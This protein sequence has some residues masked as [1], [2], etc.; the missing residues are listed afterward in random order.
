MSEQTAVE[1]TQVERLQE[2]LKHF[3]SERDYF[4]K[5]MQLAYDSN[6]SL[7]KQYERIRGMYE[8]RNREYLD[9]KSKMIQWLKSENPKQKSIATCEFI[10]SLVNKIESG[11]FDSKEEQ[12][13]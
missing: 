1:G 6:K 13:K 2:S 4:E 5:E 3:V 10:I 9:L 12:K 7:Y 11:A 8:V